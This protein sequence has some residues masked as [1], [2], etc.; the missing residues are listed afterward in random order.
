MSRRHNVLS[1]A[2]RYALL[3][4]G[5]GAASI[6]P[7]IAFAQ[8]PAPKDGEDAA[9][10]ERI[11]VTGS[12]I[13]KVDLET[14]Q[15]VLVIDR[16]EI[17]RQGFQ[18]V[19]DILQNV[20]A[21]G[22][23]AISRAQPLSAGESPGGA[24]ISLRNLGA[25]RTLILVNG[26]RLGINTNGLQDVS[27]IPTA[28]IQSIEVLKDGA[29]SVYGSDAIGGV[30]N[31][32]T[33]SNFE[34]ME[35]NAYWGQFGEGDGDIQRWDATLGYKGDRGSLVATAEYSEE[36]EVAGADRDFSRYPRGAY[37]PYL[38]WTTV[39]QWG[40]L[41]RSAA[42]GG[43][44]TLD[45]GG[46]PYDI[47][48]YHPT[49]GSAPNGD[50][51]NTNLQTDLRTPIKAKN[52]FISG[53]YH[54]NDWLRF[55]GDVMYS[56]RD[57]D[58]QVAGYPFQSA[59]FAGTT[60]SRDSY[61]NP[62]GS[63]HGAANP[64]A[65]NYQRRTWEIPRTTT[66]S[67]QTFRA[68]MGLEG[69]FELA[70]RTFDWDV[71]YLYTQ[72]KLNQAAY[73]NL[74]TVRVAQAVGPSFLNA[75]G[76]VQ[77][78]TA[79]NPIPFSSCVPWNPFLP[80]GR[81]GDGGLTNNP[82]LVNY[83]FQEEHSTGLTETK[84]YSA[85]LTGPIVTLPAGDL[86]F[87][88]GAEHRA[89]SGKFVPDALSQTASSTNLAAGP[90][91]GGYDVDE[92]YAELFVPILRDVA[93]A[94]DLSISLASRHSD[95]STFGK[96]TNNKVGFTW[97]PIEQLM[98]RGTRADG[99]RA[100]TI[101]D[102]YGGGSQTFS[103]YTDPCDTL[104]G[105]ARSNPAVQARCA[106]DI[107]N[108]ATFRQLGQGFTPTTVAN[109]QT[110]VAF[111]SGSNPLLQPEI[112]RSNTL[113]VVWSPEFSEGLNMSLDWWKIRVTETIV[114]DSPT[115]K[116]N[117]CY[118]DGIAA[119]CTGFTRDPALGYV[120]TLTFGTRNAGYV[121]TKGYDFDLSYRLPTDWGNFGIV[122]QNTYVTDL[123]FKS[124]NDPVAKPSRTNS[125]ASSGGINFR[126]R[127]NLTVNWDL[128][129]F[130]ATWGT[131]YFSGSKETC[132]SV[133]TFPDE[134]N[135]PNYIAANPADTRAINVIGANAFHD[136]QVRWKAPW[137]ATI[138]IGANNV[139]DHLAAPNY[140]NPSSS[141]TPYYGGF[142]I[143]RFYY[144]RYHQRF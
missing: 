32:I 61:Y 137:K 109:A 19:A 140:S 86:S 20:S 144:V 114:A 37:H 11:E 6:A 49:N 21:T 97:K 106:Q 100:P 44:L 71:S 56:D 70:D 38:G 58:R 22:S 118:V 67:L 104:Y 68:T 121:E 112:S 142:D 115:Q 3:A 4:G 35:A 12:R 117:D 83:L 130:G 96:T 30:V 139:F 62:L 129:D 124:T 8:S 47:T 105:A 88:F 82:E 60:M 136:L 103:F 94:K 55:R 76:R 127:S 125:F 113:G 25:Q 89:E 84:V 31:F 29:S 40:V 2:V 120:N 36:K 59:S 7:A 41:V 95:Y 46:D 135:N 119:R 69:S 24:F 10:L 65:V 91:K 133:A 122:W 15:P 57:S 53:D 123:E 48:N 17:E 92:V 80:Y 34:G 18:S 134:C 77:C 72:N 131:R 26:K 13:R 45:R 50:V 126:L 33:R 79:A 27:T 132:L 81:T 16:A 74:N 75:A 39:S 42:Q 54:I 111:T 98:F 63:Q 107:Q 87:A 52:L 78:G 28:I 5:A 138:A 51:S 43:N 14:A 93:F 116:L 102:L 108:A 101:A 66:S 1:W 110:P 64:T 99:F 141:S 23:P 73:G 85:N 90:T 143:G 128:G 9:Q